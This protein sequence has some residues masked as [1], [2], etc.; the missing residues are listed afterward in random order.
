MTEVS[1]RIVPSFPACHPPPTFNPTCF[2]RP[3]K[4]F[5]ERESVKSINTTRGTDFHRFTEH[6]VESF[7]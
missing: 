5:L 7:N 1:M 3:D 4:I 6:F 2:G